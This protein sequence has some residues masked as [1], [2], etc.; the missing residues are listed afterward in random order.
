MGILIF[1]IF[2]IALV[3]TAGYFFPVFNLDRRISA[4]VAFVL[5]VIIMY[6]ETRIRE[7]QFKVIWGSTIG[8][9]A[10]VLLGWGWGPFITPSPTTTPPRCSSGSFS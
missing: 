2:I 1:R 10:G 7:T 3:T 5:A 6:L 9:F 4:A 8:T